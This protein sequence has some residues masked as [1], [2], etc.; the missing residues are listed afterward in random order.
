MFARIWDLLKRT[1]YAFIEDGALSRGASIAFYTATSLAPVLLIVIAVAGLAF[2]RDTA[3]SA[4]LSQ[5]TGLM[6]EQ[7]AGVLQAAVASASDQTS[8][9]LAAVLGVLTL[10]LTAS[11]VFGEMQAALNAIWKAKPRGETVS[12]LIRAR[13]ASLGLV[14]ALGF[15][16]IVSLVVSASL[17]AF[18]SYLDRLLPFGQLF[19]SLVNFIVSLTLL[20]L[21]FAAIFK[22]LPDAPIGWRDVVVGAVVTAVLFT[23]GKSL[24]G[25]YLGSSA[26]ASSYG[27]AGGLI[28]LLFWI[29]YSAQIFLF[30]AEFTKAYSSRDIGQQQKS[31]D[32]S[33]AAGTCTHKRSSWS[34]GGSHGQRK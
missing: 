9:T 32:L 31:S 24:I 20:S 25:W 29:Y 3:Q 22:V 21:L 1:V 2:G 16:L 15:F 17:T 34:H 18:G 5:L 13:A 6:G 11:G 10:L 7:T 26:M 23:V 8:G 14:A 12:R 33:P 28:I 4:V 19:A 30:G 27:A